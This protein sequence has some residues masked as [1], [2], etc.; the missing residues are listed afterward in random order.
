MSNIPFYRLNKTETMQGLLR[1]HRLEM[2]FKMFENTPGVKLKVKMQLPPEKT[3]ELIDLLNSVYSG[4]PGVT[5][6][7]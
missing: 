5:E 1:L 6:H 3:V 4:K 2:F 7:I